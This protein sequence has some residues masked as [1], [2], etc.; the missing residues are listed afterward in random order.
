[1]RLAELVQWLHSTE[2]LLHGTTMAGIQ[3]RLEYLPAAF[4]DYDGPKT[5]GRVC[6]WV[7][8]LFDFEIIRIMDGKQLFF[9]HVEV[10]RI[11]DP[12]L[13][14]ALAAFVTMLAEMATE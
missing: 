8:G 9:R 11:D 12:S 2:S 13:N 14:E 4:A 5:M 3:Q 6:G 10:E 7:N 1:M